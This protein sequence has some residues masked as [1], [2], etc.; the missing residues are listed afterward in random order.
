MKADILNLEGK[1]SGSIDLPVQFYEEYRPD[2]I[3]KAVLAIQSRNRQSYGADVR[4]GKNYA[5][6][7]SRRRRDYKTA[8]GKGISRVP[9]KTMWH[10]GIQFGWVGA[11]AP[12]TVGGRRAHPPK[13][14]KIW[15]K[16]INLN[17]RKKAIR[18]A[19][20]S[21]INKDLIKNRGHLFDNV[22]III[23]NKFEDLS[24][25]KDILLVMKNIGLNLEL[26]R[27]NTKKVRPGKGKNRGRKYRTK[28]GPLIVLSNKCKLEKAASNLQGVDI[29]NIKNLNAELLAPGTNA[30]RLVIWTQNSIER[31]SKESLFL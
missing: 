25:T 20:S 29:I 28:K 18:S 11:E 1:K 2:L 26:D 3:K 5:A 14:E 9:R 4:A 24:K 13:A 8:Y 30:G 15:D 19:I 17:E 16:K 7:L 22:P 31:L 27:I 10:R 23:E 6:K 12:G 21:T